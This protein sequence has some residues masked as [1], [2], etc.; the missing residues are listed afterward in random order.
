MSSIAT[1]SPFTLPDVGRINSVTFIGVYFDHT[2]W[3]YQHAKLKENCNHST[4]CNRQTVT[5]ILFRFFSP[6]PFPSLPSPFP[7]FPLPR[8]GLFK[9]SLEVWRSAV[10]SL[11]GLGR[12]PSCKPIFRT[13]RAQG[14]RLMLHIVLQNTTFKFYSVVWRHYSDEVPRNWRYINHVIIIIIMTWDVLQYPHV[15]EYQ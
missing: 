7:P 3:F 1:F 15:Y 13:F 12:S 6:L 11:T 10:S 2:M 14:T 4:C 5:R 8:S 9:S